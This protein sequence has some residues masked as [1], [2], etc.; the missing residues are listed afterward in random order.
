MGDKPTPNHTIDR[1][2][3]DLGYEPGN[4]RWATTKRADTTIEQIC[5]NITYNGITQTLA[6]WARR[7]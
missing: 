1:I 5:R 2:N 4:C 6:Q 3:N 7:V